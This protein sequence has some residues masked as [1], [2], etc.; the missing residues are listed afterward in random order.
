M[1]AARRRTKPA[2]QAARTIAQNRDTALADPHPN[3]PPIYRETVANLGGY[4][5]APKLGGEVR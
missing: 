4:P 3:D 2:A 1:P 5:V